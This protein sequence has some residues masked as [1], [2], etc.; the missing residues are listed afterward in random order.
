M[1][2]KYFSWV[3]DI[4]GKSEETITISSDINT[5]EK[6]IDFLIKKNERYKKAF[7]KRSTIKVAQN[8]V[9]I[10][11]SAKIKNTDEIAFFPPV[12]GG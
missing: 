1:I 8:K 5:P 12:T 10:S 4:I 2:I 6:L 9:Y 7:E 11:K 3:K